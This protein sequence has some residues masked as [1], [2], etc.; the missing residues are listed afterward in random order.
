MKCVVRLG[1]I[2]ALAAIA[3][4]VAAHAGEE[5]AAS[6]PLEQELG[7]IARTAEARMKEG[8]A[9]ISDLLKVQIAVNYGKH[10]LGAM[11]REELRKANGPL[12]ERLLQAT[13]AAYASKQI[14]TDEVVRVLDFIMAHQ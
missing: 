2:V 11:S 14:G 13:R 5:R 4:A 12:A 10:K 3:C 8:S 7:K 6:T 9:S 1:G